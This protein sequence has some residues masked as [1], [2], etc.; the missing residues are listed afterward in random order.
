MDYYG[1][2][3]TDRG[4]LNCPLHGP[5]RTPSLKIYYDQDRWHCYGC[6]RGGTVIDLVMEMDNL[7]FAEACQKMP[8]MFGIKGHHLSKAERATKYAERAEREIRQLRHDRVM[9]N[10]TER[11]RAAWQT[12]QRA[13][14]MSDEWCEAVKAL[15]ELE[16]RL[17]VEV[18]RAGTND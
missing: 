7:S 3:P 17:E 18:G 12:K 15:P 8:K 10:L 1:L 5:E 4:Y 14:P 9:K 2:E 11:H 6:N 16:W 13:E